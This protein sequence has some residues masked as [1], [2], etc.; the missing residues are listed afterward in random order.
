MS[1]RN[2]VCWYRVVVSLIKYRNSV[3]MG[4]SDAMQYATNDEAN[5]D[6]G[7]GSVIRW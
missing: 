6:D 2:A 1:F 5:D 7:K 4:E 3:I